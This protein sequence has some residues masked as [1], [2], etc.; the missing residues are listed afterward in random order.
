ML[1]IKNAFVHLP[2]LKAILYLHSHLF[3]FP[4]ISSQDQIPAWFRWLVFDCTVPARWGFK[5]STDAERIGAFVHHLG[6]FLEP[7]AA[8]E[9]QICQAAI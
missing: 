4:P 9:F 3:F 7:A 1:M 5:V 2:L 8:T 6:H